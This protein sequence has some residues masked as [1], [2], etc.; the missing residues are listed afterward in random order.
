MDESPFHLFSGKVPRQS[1]LNTFDKGLKTTYSNIIHIFTFG[2]SDIS[3][4]QFIINLVTVSPCAYVISNI[5][6]RNH[7]WMCTPLLVF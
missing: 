5:E 1:D 7:L 6:H 4:I 3:V 2:E